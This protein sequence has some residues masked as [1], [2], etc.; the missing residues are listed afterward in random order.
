MS[1]RNLTAAVKT[2]LSASAL[3]YRWLVD[4]EFKG[5]P[6]FTVYLWNGIGDITFNSNVYQGNGWLQKV[7]TP[8]EDGESTAHGIDIIMTGIPQ[9]I[10][11][12]ILSN[13]S[14]SKRARVRLAFLDSSGF[15][16]GDPYLVFEGNIDVPEIIESSDEPQIRFAIENDLIDLDRARDF[17]FT[18][19]SQ[20]AAIFESGVTDKGFEYVAGMEDWEGYWGK[21]KKKKKKKKKKNRG[22]GKKGRQ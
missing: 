8:A 14:Q 9:T 2:E 5:T 21:R 6:D 10:L 20:K 13:V 3:R 19:E 17:R 18:D 15:I 12:A 1:S 4:L 16:I 22:R 11:S 7:T